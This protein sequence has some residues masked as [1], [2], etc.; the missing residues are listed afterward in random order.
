MNRDGIL[1][2]LA[3][4]VLLLPLVLVVPFLILTWKGKTK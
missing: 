1:D 3:A 4:L 2:I